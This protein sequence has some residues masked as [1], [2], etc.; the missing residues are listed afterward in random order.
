MSRRNDHIPEIIGFMLGLV[1]AIGLV[2]TGSTYEVSP[3]Q[4][5]IQE[6]QRSVHNEF[7]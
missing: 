3:E 7:E 5:Q 4:M 1:L 2:T 6:M